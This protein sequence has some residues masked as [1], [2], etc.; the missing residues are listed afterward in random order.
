MKALMQSTA[1][2]M[3]AIAVGA[4]G[5]A[6]PRVSPERLKGEVT[7][8]IRYDQAGCPTTAEV[9]PA[10]RSCDRADCVALSR[11]N[12]NTVIFESPDPKLEFE[13]FFDPFKNDSIKSRNGRAMATIDGDTPVH[14]TYS[15]FIAPA[16]QH[17][18]PCAIPDP[19]I[20][21]MP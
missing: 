14:K 10:A 11:K 18:P 5:C 3:V 19:T 13:L 17:S 15:F 20:I 7:F 1:V 9:G 21:I 6:G 4:S 12:R 16:P 8:H 2:V